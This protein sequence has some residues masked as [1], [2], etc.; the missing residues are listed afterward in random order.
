MDGKGEPKDGETPLAMPEEQDFLDFLG[1][2][3]VEPWERH[4]RGRE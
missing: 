1:L 4:A 2:A 3:W